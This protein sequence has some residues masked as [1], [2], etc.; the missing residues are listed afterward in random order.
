M[1]ERL[2][3][4]LEY[5]TADNQYV[6][7]GTYGSVELKD[8]TTFPIVDPHPKLPSVS[9]FDDTVFGFPKYSVTFELEERDSKKVAVNVR[10]DE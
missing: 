8:G 3:G 5:Y 1:A 4:Y 6:Q 7:D 9:V 2:S 10:L